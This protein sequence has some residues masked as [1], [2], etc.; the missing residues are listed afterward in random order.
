MTTRARPMAVTATLLA[1][2]A[3]GGCTGEPE[4]SAGPAEPSPTRGTPTAD[5]PDARQQAAP[6]RVGFTRVAGGVRP[7]E[8]ERFRRVLARPVRQWVQAGF[9]KGP[10]PRQGFRAA[11]R[12]FAHGVAPAARRDMRLLTLH[13]HGGTF[14]EVVP[15]RREV[16]LSATT[17]Q[18]RVVGATARVDLRVL[19][20]D[21]TRRRTSVR[22]RGDLYLTRT[23]KQGW[24]IFGYRLHRKVSGE[25]A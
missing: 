24:Q 20:L 10:W 23:P 9:V 25:R 16:T 2:V 19:G 14:V 8:R 17:V 13:P 6:Y 1:A 21:E 7:S 22:V 4:Q 15:Q 5:A 12:P 18:G 11:F 3:L